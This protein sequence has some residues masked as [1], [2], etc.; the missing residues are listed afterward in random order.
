MGTELYH[1]TSDYLVDI[2]VCVPFLLS[3][4][5]PASGCSQ[6]VPAIIDSVKTLSSCACAH[7]ASLSLILLIKPKA[8][9]GISSMR[10]FNPSCF[11]ASSTMQA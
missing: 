9:S 2:M 1:P 8:N 3:L 6:D 5:L 10:D 4:F 7:Q 11:R